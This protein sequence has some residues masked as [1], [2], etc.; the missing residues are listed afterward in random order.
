MR[1]KGAMILNRYER[2]DG[3]QMPLINATMTRREIF[4]AIGSMLPVLVAPSLVAHAQD[5]SGFPEGYDA[6]QA[7]PGSHK[8]AFEND[9]VRV[10]QVIV[11]PPGA[12]EPM[13]HHRWPSFFLKWDKGGKS[14]HIRYI[15]PDGSVRDVP[16]VDRPAHPG[17]WMVQWMKP[18]PM[19]SIHVVERPDIRPDDPTLLRIE[20]K[21]R[22]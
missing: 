14:P 22:T 2:T 19:H 11:P 6:V 15:R 20:I 7:A 4:A 18:E 12:T 9:F 13:H 10:L 5:A 16:S 8:V 21:S 17:K 1:G 3:M